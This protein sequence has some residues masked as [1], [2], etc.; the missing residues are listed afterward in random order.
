LVCYGTPLTNLDV[1]NNTNL[2][3]LWCFENKLTSLD[4]SKNTTLVWL[5]CSGNQLT[6]D[7]LDV[8]F[9]TLH[10]NTITLPMP[11]PVTKEITIYDNPGTEDCNP[12]IATKKGWTVNKTYK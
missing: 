2:V 12:S 6:A 8:L 10:S 7:N 1:S 3:S 4:V 9:G 5:L 11:V